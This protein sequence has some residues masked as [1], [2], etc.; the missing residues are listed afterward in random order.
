MTE[1]A[2]L[3]RKTVSA[4]GFANPLNLPANVE[5]ETHV[6]V[7]GDDELLSLGVDYTVEGAGDTGDL[8]E[9]EGV[10]IILDAEVL[11]RDYAT[12]TVEHTPPL[13]QGVDLSSGGTLG[14]IYMQGLDAI[15][16]R[17]QTLG[18]A[19]GRRL[20]LP[21][22]SDASPVLPTP[23]PRRALV[24]NEAGDA[25]VIIRYAT[26][27]EIAKSALYLA[28]DASSFTTGVALLVDAGVSINRT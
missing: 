4:T 23:E 17:V 2:V 7:Y 12:Y 9:I 11:L 25:L 1:T 6:S 5:D 10:N 22:D 24:W 19:I 16:R 26:P 18:A 20:V 15:V 28:S 14:R 8:D 13:D 21:V 3:Q 27:D